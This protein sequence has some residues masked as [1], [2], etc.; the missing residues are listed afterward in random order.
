MGLERSVH[1]NMTEHP[2]GIEPSRAGHSIGRWEDDVLV[3]DTVGFLPGILSAD[4]RVPHSDRLHVVERF[5]LSA[6][7]RTLRRSYVAE[8]PLY[9]QGE[10]KGADAV[11]VA[12]AAY[13]PIPCD[14]RSYKAESG[15]SGSVMIGI[16]VAL[17]GG[18]VLLLAGAWL[19]RHRSRGSAA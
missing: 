13:Q 15:E 11:H 18:L 19:L 3:V 14:D 4:G 9:L 2:A 12:D 10:Y 5:A 17:A 1:L 16:A 6:D 8:D 7:G